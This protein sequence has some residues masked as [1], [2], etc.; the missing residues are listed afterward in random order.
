MINKIIINDEIY[1]KKGNFSFVYDITGEESL[2]NMCLTG[3]RNVYI[4]EDACQVA[5]RKAYEGFGRYFQIGREINENKLSKEEAIR[6]T[7]DSVS[8]D[9]KKKAVN[10]QQTYKKMLIDYVLML[11][12]TQNQKKEEFTKLVQIYLTCLKP[13]NGKRIKDIR[14]LLIDIYAKLS[15]PMHFN[16][17]GEN[18]CINLTRMFYR[19]I[20]ILLDNKDK[21]KKENIPLGDYYPIT[22]KV[23]VKLR[24]RVDDN[25]RMYIKEDGRYYLFKKKVNYNNDEI[26]DK[27]SAREIEVLDKLW[28]EESDNPNH[29]PLS[30]G[31]IGKGDNVFKVYAFPSKPICLDQACNDEKYVEKRREIAHGLIKAILSLQNRETP[32]VLRTLNKNSIFLCEVKN[33]IKVY[34]VRFNTAKIS[35]Y[36]SKFTVKENIAKYLENSYIS[37]EVKNG[38]ASLKSDIYSLGKI[39]FDL[40]ENTDDTYELGIIRA[41]CNS[42]PDSRPSIQEIWGT[43]KDVGQRDITGDK[44]Y[45]NVFTYPYELASYQLSDTVEVGRLTDTGIKIS[46]KIVSRNHGIIYREGERYYYRDLESTNGTFV[47]GKFLGRKT[48]EYKNPISDGTV[49]RIDRSEHN[50]PHIEAVVIFIC[51]TDN[52]SLKS[53]YITFSSEP[54]VIN[55]HIS[56]YRE[57]KDII[58]ESHD[59]GYHINGQSVS[60]RQ[61][62]NK[63]DVVSDGKVYAIFIEEGVYVYDYEE[64]MRTVRG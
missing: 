7:E 61:I 63:Y 28:N 58:V 18:D 2:Y 48:S 29:V 3:E 57:N 13:E 38:T 6:K 25:T 36:E 55:G 26:T 39:L 23:G 14:G 49:I 46:S 10:Q 60:G 16:A 21:F 35:D 20:S 51:D 32:I 5:L 44:L 1:V 22:G 15:R 42:E 9:N 27:T 31:E 24:V 62:V 30:F 17:Q 50:D 34:I 4:N 37:P 19:L 8:F 52:N 53:D 64:D 41:M 11:N 54:I 43:W 59:K 56:I 45:A 40:Y 33:K 47:N 12:D